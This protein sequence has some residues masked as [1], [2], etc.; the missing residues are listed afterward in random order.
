MGQTRRANRMTSATL[1]K[2]LALLAVLVGFAMSGC[3]G[4]GSS[5]SK[6][7]VSVGLTPST[8]QA[9]D[10]G[11]KI[12]FT[13]T[14]TNDSSG[15][16][17]T[18]S[19]SGQGTLSNQ[20]TTAATYTAPTS[21]TPGTGSVT[22]TSVADPTKNSSVNITVTAPPVISATPLSAATIGTPY[23]QTVGVTGG[24]GALTFSIS[25]GSLPTG[26]NLNTT[27]G[28]ITGTPTGAT[29]TTNFSVKVSDSST[30][31][32]LSAAQSL[33]ITVNP[34][35][36]LTITTANLLNPLVGETYNQTLQFSGASATLPVV[37]SIKSGTLPAGL[38]L[39]A[40]T[41]AIT[42]SPTTTG[43][44][45]FT[46]ELA[47]SSTPAATTTQMLTLT[48][49]STA[50][51]GSGSESLLKGQYAL[52][53]AG[54]D[55]SGPVGMLGSFTA[56]G[57][58]KI[59]AGVEDINSSGPNGVQ[60]NLP[61]T[62]ASS[63]YAIG[64]DNKGCLTL[65]AGGVTR[66]FRFTAGSI[67]G[68]VAQGGRVVEFDFTGTN[69]AG[70]IAIQQPQFF[71][72]ASVQ[73]SFNFA[74]SSPLPSA[75]G[76]GYST[77]VG[78]LNLSGTTVNGVAD[79]NTNGTVDA[80]NSQYPASP[81][82][83][84]PGMYSIGANGRG[85]LSFTPPG[86]PTVD[87]IVYVL[88]AGQLQLLSSDA[89][90]ATNPAYTGF[91]G[92]QSG[93]P[94]G[95]STLKGASVLFLSGQTGPGTSNSSRIEAGLFNADGVS[96][97]NFSGDLNSGGSIGTPSMTGSYS[98]AANG[99]VLVTTAGSSTPALIM[100]LVNTNEGLVMSTDSQ[101]MVGDVEPQTGGPFT[102]SSLSGT[103]AIATVDPVVPSNALIEG[104]EVYDGAGNVNATFELND[105][106]WLSLGN[107]IS[108]TYTVSSNGRVIRTWNGVS[109]RVGYIIS[110]GRLVTLGNTA[111]DTS[112]TLVISQQ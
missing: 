98:V 74:M 73:G 54:F 3:G 65:V 82:T 109:Q 11:Q 48:V 85:T 60:S 67:N 95:N 42:G 91:A 71:S 7:I 81:I 76:G 39:N 37:W 78:V 88:D 75:A 70:T 86:A 101:V 32:P 19:E 33:S 92:A 110:P 80:G 102:N 26:L 21:G 84:T 16:G 12:Q 59:T 79:I 9:I 96:S 29:G 93:G 62:T 68:G 56:D 2:V 107:A 77:T 44:S 13:A 103:Y 53:M 6:P 15:Q 106:G 99:R 89:Q 20:T 34:P 4:G 43:T 64:S 36:V 49:T 27:T 23:S 28:A 5:N 111:S 8:P 72:N 57:T 90:S 30:A 58:G 52:S 17:V 83:F 35:V 105:G 97:F 31:G 41:G 94:Y 108:G 69:T 38:S 1:K 40:S 112:P 104:A 22:A 10:Q 55:G 100:Y 46:V 47:D 51:C 25:S 50:M 24:A 66:N 87:L 63:S 14:V 61:I 45:N 18:W